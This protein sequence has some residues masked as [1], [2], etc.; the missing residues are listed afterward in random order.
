[1]RKRIYIFVL[2]YYVRFYSQSS[3]QRARTELAFGY[4]YFSLYSLTHGYPIMHH[5]GFLRC[6]TALFY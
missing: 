1:M 2:R 3:A 5:Q 4:G 6:Y